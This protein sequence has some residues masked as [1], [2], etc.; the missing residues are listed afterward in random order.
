VTTLVL[1][2]PAHGAAW[3]PFADSRPVA[4]LRAGIWLIRERWEASVGADCARILGP[5]HLHAFAEERVPPV[6]PPA[7][8]HGPAVIGRSDFA[9]AGHAPDLPDAPSRLTNEGETV[10]WWVPDGHT[11]HGTDDDIPDETE[12]AGMQ[13]LGTYDLLTALDT[14]LDPD[15]ADFTLERGDTLPDEMVILGDPGDIVMLGASVEPGVIVDVRGGPVV[16]EHRAY[17]R[18]GTRLEGPLYIGPG[19]LVAGGEL[20]RSVIGPRC[21]VR[22]DIE[23]SVFVGYAN[24]SHDG[25]VG[26]SVIGRWVNLGA[27][28]T[29]SNLKNTYGPI[30]LDIGGNVVD[31]ER[32][33]LGSLI[34]DHAKVAIGTLFT[35]GTVVGVGANVFGSSHPPRFVPPFAWGDTGDT[36]RLDGFLTVAERVMPRRDVEFTDAVRSALESIYTHVT[37]G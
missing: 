20:R 14:L 10:G 26:H 29:T 7:P 28:T 4:E 37:A 19:C 13:L 11:W 32:Q 6:G 36:A 30:S 18:A 24:K 35:T 34:G 8:V 21:R 2:E 9:P 12:I 31:T 16:L 15:A 33:F 17:V 5:P 1:L 22:G 3:Q 23:S 25:F 27:G